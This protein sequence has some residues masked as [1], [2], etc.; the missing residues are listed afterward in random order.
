[1]SMLFSGGF[2]NVIPDS[3]ITNYE[4]GDLSAWSG[5]TGV[6][7][8]NTNAPVNEGSY[9]LKYPSGES[10]VTFI[11]SLPGDGLDYYPEVGVPHITDIYAEGTG[12][13]DNRSKGAIIYGH[14]SRS[15]LADGY[16]IRFS[17]GNTSGSDDREIVIMRLDS[18]SPT[19]LDSGSMA[20]PE[21][22]FWQL[23]TL[24]E[25]DGSITARSLSGGSEIDRV[26]A[27]DSTHLTSG[28]FDNRGVGHWHVRL[29][30]DAA[31]DWR[32]N[33]D[34]GLI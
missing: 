13:F 7:A 20:L 19:L 4:S 11:G 32:T 18:G 34:S 26:T 24:H 28:E 8:V 1:M 14:S 33:P 6:F 29:T 27:S 30:D 25:S 21:A 17:Y 10:G 3:G 15:Q 22:E 16:Q 12:D 23:E 2:F 9:S 5:D 31:D